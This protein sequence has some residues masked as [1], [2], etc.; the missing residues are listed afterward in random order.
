MNMLVSGISEKNGK[1]IAYVLF[2]EENRSAEAVIP[3]CKVMSNR[4]FTDEEVLQLEQY[5]RDNLAM[6][7]SQAASVNPITAMM[8]E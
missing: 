4:N 6:L 2:E 3:A 7:K 5:M 8:K 1:R